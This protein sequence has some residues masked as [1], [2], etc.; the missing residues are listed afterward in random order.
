MAR[1][2]KLLP[3]PQGIGAGQTATLSLPL[4]STY[5]QLDLRLKAHVSGTPVDVAAADWGDFIDDIRLLVDGNSKIE[6][7]AEYLVNRAQ[8]YGETL[9][10]GVLPIFLGMPWARTMGG[11]D[12]TAYGTAAGMASFTLEVDF[13]PGVNIGLF[14][15]YAIQSA[16]TQ[17]GAHVA[18]QRFARSFSSIGVDEVADIPK[19][20][21]FISE[22]DI[23]DANIDD[24]DV[25]ADG[26]I[27]FET[28]QAIRDQRHSIAGR[29]PQTGFT[30]L[31]FMAENRVG[32][33]FPMVLRDFR[34]KLDFT[35]A[36]GSYDIYVTS[37][38]G[39]T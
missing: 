13:K 11:E 10:A 21:Y 38:R 12:Q 35:T 18:I 4:G 32:E 5:H 1:R 33:V 3:T 36:P 31:D 14:K 27:I 15:V 19:G 16:A 28:D 6:A 24:I 30:H 29:V 37:I 7:T 22:I 26:R 39:R 17:F 8:Y 9:T 2:I 34:L 23:D 20:A 25:E